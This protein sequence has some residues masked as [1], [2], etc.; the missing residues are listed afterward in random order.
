V[1]DTDRL[2]KRGLHH[3]AACLFCDQVEETIHHI[4][5]SCVFAKQVW[6]II[7]LGLGL[8]A[9]TPHP[10]TTNFSR[11]WSGAVKIVPK[12]QKMDFH[13]LVEM[14]P[15]SFG[16]IGVIVFSIPYLLVGATTQEE[17]DVRVVETNFGG[18][19]F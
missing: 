5:V 1:L 12:E 18:K 3:P 7:L 9:A 13:S 2:A 16:S 6:C 4:L 15:R 11:R 17:G 14:L 19:R 10:G 8:A